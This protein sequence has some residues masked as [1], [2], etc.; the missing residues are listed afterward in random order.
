MTPA[1]THR[2]LAAALFASLTLP[3]GLPAVAQANP[4]PAV[5]APAP[6]TPFDN[7][8]S[9]DAVD[10]SL[11]DVV[12]M[13]NEQPDKPSTRIEQAFRSNQ[14]SLISQW[15]PKYGL[16]AGRQF[17]Y[18]V[19]GFA[20]RV[21]ANKIAELEQEP[22][23]ASVHRERVYNHYEH[24]ARDLEGVARAMKAAGLD[25]SGTVVS[26]IDSGIDVTHQ[27]MRLDDGKCETAK[28]TTIK[29]GFTC[30][31]PTGYDYADEDND[32]KDHSG[33]MHGMHVAGIVG[34]N[35]SVGDAPEDVLVNGRIDGV[36]PNAQLLAMK[37]FSDVGGGAW[38][39]DIIAA[40]E[41][42]VKLGAD[43]INMSLGSTNG[44]NDPSDG[45]YRAMAKAQEA[46]VITVVAAGNEGANFSLGG[47]TSNFGAADG[48]GKLDDATIGAPGTQGP[49]FTVAS[50]DNGVTTN[51]SAYYNDG[52]IH[53]FPYLPQTG[54]A[55]GAE[56][57][58]AYMGLGKED[59]YAADT[60]L[61]GK[62]ALI[63]RG[64]ITFE[65]KF[66]RAVDHGA[67]G[68]LVFNGDG[69]VGFAGM[70]GIEA[71]TVFGASLTNE[72]GHAIADA[73]AAN[74]D[75][76]V[77]FTKD[78]SL[79]AN[80]T[81]LH[82]SSF[83]SWG[84]TPTLDFEPEVAGIGGSVYSTLNDNTY[85]TM[86]GTS[87]AS[88]NVAGMSA[89]VMQSFAERF[90]ELAGVERTDLT[91]TALMNT[92]RILEDE[93]G[94]PFSPRQ[95]GA[96]LAQVDKAAATNVFATVDGKPSVALRE[97]TSAR[98]FTVTLTN[99]GDADVTYQVPAQRVLNEYWDAEGQTKVKVSNETLKSD[100]TE[101]TVP[102]GGTATVDFTLT[103]RSGGDDHYVL[104][105]AQLASAD[106]AVPSLAVPYMGFVGDWNAE[107]IMLAPGEKLYDMLP[108]V[109]A[110]YTNFAGFMEIGLD[111][112]NVRL[113][114][115]GPFDSIYPKVG[116]LRNAHELAYE[117]LDAD[118]NL[119]KKL[120][121]DQ[122]VR[123]ETLADQ[124]AKW[125]DMAHS[126]ESQSFDGT[127]WDAQA[128]DFVNVP[129]GDYIYRVK[130]RLGEGFD[131]QTVDLPFGVDGT[132]PVITF[133]ELSGKELPFEATDE[134][135]GLYDIPQ[136]FLPGGAETT[137]EKIDDTHFKVVFDDANPVPDYVTVIATDHGFNDGKATKVLGDA[138]LV[139]P[140]ADGYNT[141]LGPSSL[142][143]YEDKAAIEGFVSSDVAKV[144]IAGEEVEIVN[145][146]FVGNAPLVE[147][148]NTIEVIAYNDADEEVARVTIT[149]VYDKTPPT[150]EIL[151]MATDAAGD[152]VVDTDGTITVKAKVSDERAGAE[153]SASVNSQ[154]ADIDADGVFTVT[155]TPDDEQFS[156][157][158]VASDGPNTTTETVMISGRSPAVTD[159]WI[160]PTITNVECLADGSACF[161]PG[162]HPD[163]TED[164]LVVRGDAPS[165]VS[166]FEFI[167]GSRAQDDGSFTQPEVISVTPNADGSFEATLPMTTGINDFALRVWDKENN[168][169]VERSIKFFFDVVAPTIS[170][171]EP[172]LINGTLFTNKDEVT[173]AGTAEDDGWGY[174][175]MLND[176]SVVEVFYLTGLGPESNQRTFSEDVAVADGD[177]L[178]VV[179]RDANGNVLIGAIPVVV[180]K[181]GPVLSFTTVAD[182]E[183]ISDGRVINV[184]AT[185][186]NLATM[187][188]TL[189]NEEL[190]NESTDQVVTPIHVEDALVDARELGIDTGSGILANSNAS[191]VAGPE[192]SSDDAAAPAND[193]ANPADDSAAP[194][195]DATDN[196]VDADGTQTHP[197][198]TTLSYD[199]ETANLPAGV[200][201]LTIEASDLAGNV[202]A[203]SRTFTIDAPAKIVGPDEVTEEVFR[204]V[205]DDQ[206]ALAAA[207]VANYQV[208]D[209]GVPSDPEAET[210]LSV[211]EGTVIVEGEQ[212]VV[213]VATDADGK[214]VTRTVKVTVAIKDVTLTDGDVSAT[215]KFRSD[216][217]LTATITEGED[218]F[219]HTLT[220]SNKE[221]NAA[222]VASISVPAAEGTRVWVDA[223][224]GTKTEVL[225][226]WVDGVLTFEGSSKGT[227]YLVS[228][229]PAPEP[230]APAPGEPGG[231][232]KPGKPT[233]PEQP[234]DNGKPGN[235]GKPA[236][237]KKPGTPGKDGKLSKT[238]ADVTGLGMASLL[239]AGLGAAVVA[240]RRRRQH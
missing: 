218:E 203:E 229:E 130:A 170:F 82:P 211:K 28:I 96:G 124:A 37:V 87:M 128:A 68:V 149:T 222:Q 155:F 224:D 209:D 51:P 41:D 111:E 197:A 181:E 69:Q 61:S 235:D 55:D 74:P 4:A 45:A 144:T 100:V 72:D 62:Y 169:R 83:T 90:P 114:P 64:E 65:E 110:L 240:T 66:Q 16:K 119:V 84:P 187:R 148:E 40:I 230:P 223:G 214:T 35:A 85:G 188:V 88:P 135:S 113:S 11:V 18:L 194:A 140:D 232:A 24:A 206:D 19:N 175:L 32:V 153:L 165:E 147:G 199:V 5:T 102:A 6:T 115:G 136:A 163:V 138:K 118:G 213:L 204:E 59:D 150:I 154:P 112:Y 109:T 142:L 50:V 172:V 121:T 8:E 192:I 160:E 200:Y 162:N 137:V 26:I 47:D 219:H 182:G 141:V 89:L 220:V 166:R 48:L 34:A 123:R 202:S 14:N 106:P 38:D 208:E 127:V 103:T 176:S 52:E 156:F 133:G 31:I 184:S 198:Q 101:V 178:L 75:T 58:V 221:E 30:K 226:T 177:T 91:R 54:E 171:D 152:A 71:F 27:D 186:D 201:T 42:S 56:H 227:Y 120:G 180:D 13:L 117:V 210:V 78:L 193:S 95:M 231:P 15:G 146:K 81:G 39:S 205:A 139:V 105:W 49:A 21:P 151:E 189:N 92:T 159:E 216:D 57:A 173:F 143:I 22:A 145:G 25:G 225:A 157:P 98:A 215:G 185:D 236:D 79:V 168:Q 70:A 104:G 86:S 10:T 196:T 116:L 46:G 23:V 158:I 29:D 164:S 233:V 2:Y 183:I 67:E 93:N 43:V 17:S 12:V 238:G 234:G 7:K 107:P 60:D 3:V 237:P 132:A 20:A 94:I 9:G 108:T 191:D 228:P 44:Q 76:T 125:S 174:E 161:I 80:P 73:L 190:Y 77:R 36:A 122:N 179:F 126:A 131:W 134:G 53:P 207:I 99:R 33:S 239:A 212:D 195:N 1:K 167:P 63:M 129:D 97:I 217:A